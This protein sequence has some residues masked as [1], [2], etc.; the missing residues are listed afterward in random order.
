MFVAQ[1]HDSR[2]SF[3]FRL[4]CKWRWN[5]HI[6]QRFPSSPECTSDLLFNHLTFESELSTKQPLIL[7]DDNMMC[8]YFS[9]CQMP[10][11]NLINYRSR[12]KDQTRRIMNPIKSIHQLPSNKPTRCM[13]IILSLLVILQDSSNY[14]CQL[15]GWFSC[16]P[17]KVK[18]YQK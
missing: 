9:N 3:L 17:Q 18:S 8:K 11:D 2:S 13:F 14:F 16:T 1:L 4:G 7:S 12:G 6:L 15:K 5:K 10:A